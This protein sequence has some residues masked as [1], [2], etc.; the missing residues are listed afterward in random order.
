MGNGSLACASGTWLPAALVA[1]LPATLGAIT[2]SR[3]SLS[4]DEAVDAQAVRT[5]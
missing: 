4:H 3:R 5:S 1:L 2:L